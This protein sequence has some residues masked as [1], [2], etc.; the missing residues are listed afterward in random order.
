M[1][2]WIDL[3]KTF[4]LAVFMIITAGYYIIKA[5]RAVWVDLILHSRDNLGREA[6]ELM[7]KARST[8]DEFTVALM[9]LEQGHVS[10]RDVSTRI[11]DAIWETHTKAEEVEGLC[12]E[13]F[14]EIRRRLPRPSDPPL[15][16]EKSAPSSPPPSQPPSM[17]PSTNMPHPGHGKL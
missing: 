8:L 4:G 12:R 11:E 9:R 2:F 16:S 7:K 1:E 10:A 15:G 3:L 5:V 6:V 17:T 13:I 14:V